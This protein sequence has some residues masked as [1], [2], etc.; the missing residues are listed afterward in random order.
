MYSISNM[1]KYTRF[2]PKFDTNITKHG[3]KVEKCLLMSLTDD[4][5]S[6]I[7]Y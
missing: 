4:Q 5:M 2:K 6:L 7:A 3:R 1:H